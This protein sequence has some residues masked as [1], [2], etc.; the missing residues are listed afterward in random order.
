MTSHPHPARRTSNGGRDLFKRSWLSAQLL[1]QR[2]AEQHS[3]CVWH[4][5]VVLIFRVRYLSTRNPGPASPVEASHPRMDHHYTRYPLTTHKMT[6]AGS[7]V[8]MQI[9]PC[10]NSKQTP[11]S[12]W[13]IHPSQAGNHP[14]SGQSLPSCWIPP[15]VPGRS[16]Q[17]QP[18]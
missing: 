12:L 1:T 8:M 6:G 4:L 3:Q 14:K 10:L 11:I 13:G 15:Q 2:R 9:I 17:S 16:V 7:F 5:K 18:G